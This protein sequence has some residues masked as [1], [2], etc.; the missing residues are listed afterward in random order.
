[1]FPNSDVAIVD[2]R[3]F[4]VV[5]AKKLRNVTLSLLLAY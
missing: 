2:V 1:M 3:S 5:L 4:N